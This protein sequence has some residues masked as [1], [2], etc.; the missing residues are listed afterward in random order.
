[1]VAYELESNRKIRMWADELKALIGAPFPV[2]RDSLFVAFYASAELGCFKFLNWPMPVNV[3]DLFMEFRCLTNGIVGK[4]HRSLLGALNHFKLPAV[5]GLFKTEMRD[6]AIRGG[7][8]TEEERAA[9]LDYSESDTTAL[10]H[11]LAEMKGSIDIES[12][13]LR[14]RFAIATA[15][16]EYNGVPVDSGTYRTLTENWEA[17]QDRLIAEVDK[18]Y[19]VYE[20]RTFKYKKLLDYLVHNNL[21]WPVLDSGTLDLQTNTFKDMARVYPKLQNLTELRTTLSQLQLKD[22]AVGREGRNRCLLSMLGTITGRNTPSNKG[23]VF[24]PA[25]WLRGLIKPE[26]ETALAY[27]DFSQQEFV[28]AAALSRDALM[29]EAYK[30][31]DPYL[32]FTRQVG[33]VPPGATKEIH[34]EIRELFKQC[35]LGTQYGI[36]AQALAIRIGKSPAYGKDLLRLHRNTYFRF[37]EFV[38]SVHN[39]AALRGVLWTV[40]EWRLR[41]GPD[42]NPRGHWA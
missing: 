35:I 40:H 1:M 38:E 9:L 21:P 41:V 18:D 37:W 19:G 20:G 10:I 27:V 28:I 29:M 15:E 30:T 16:M 24:G 34:P 39:Q 17:I 11:L 22:L 7:P 2:G 8:F 3:L 23:F 25:T 14:G 6:L 36:G 13:L 12:A 31:K 26:P 5:D 4:G 33:A 32:E 42:F